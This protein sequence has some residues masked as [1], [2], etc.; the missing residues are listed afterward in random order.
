MTKLLDVQVDQA[1]L[2]DLAKILG[3]Y[4]SAPSKTDYGLNDIR[5]AVIFERELRAEVI[6]CILLLMDRRRAEALDSELFD[7]IARVREA[8]TA[9][10]E[11]LALRDKG[12]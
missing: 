8:I 6:H 2:D 10:H 5:G 7:A 3:D 11:R 9:M 1:F 12:L 4:R